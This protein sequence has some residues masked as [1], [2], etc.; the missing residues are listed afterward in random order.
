MDLAVQTRGDWDLVLSAARWAEDRG[1]VAIALPD[2][3]LERGD[4]TDGP[5]YDHLVHL[6]ALARETS[7]DRTGLAP[8]AGD[9]PS[10]R[11]VLQD[12]CHPG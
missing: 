3:Y 5:A 6:A 10:P 1:L 11:G 2:H 9:L 7:K 8:L 4:Q 12:G